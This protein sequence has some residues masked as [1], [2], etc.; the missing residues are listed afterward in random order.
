MKCGCGS[1]FVKQ[2]MIT[3]AWTD[4]LCS[5]KE[6]RAK[7]RTFDDERPQ[8]AKPRYMGRAD[9][10]VYSE[11]PAYWERVAREALWDALRERAERNAET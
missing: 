7:W 4:W 1:E 2:P 9:P 10:S 8:Y 3:G 6:C 11:D 5:N